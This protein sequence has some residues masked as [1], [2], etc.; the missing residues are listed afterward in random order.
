MSLSRILNDGMVDILQIAGVSGAVV[1]A[2]TM[3]V[4]L[5]I[6]GW[7]VVW[8]VFLSKFPLFRALFGYQ[9][10]SENLSGKRRSTAKHRQGHRSSPDQSLRSSVTG[11]YRRTAGQ[12]GGDEREEQT[13]VDS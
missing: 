12:G 4:L 2:V 6:G 3:A 13:S 10:E 9:E 5:I 1:I 7:Y 8:K 11:S